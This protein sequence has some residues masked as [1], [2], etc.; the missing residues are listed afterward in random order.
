M[1]FRSRPISLGA[2]VL[3]GMLIG[4]AAQAQNSPPRYTVTDLG[5]LGGTYSYAYGLNDAD[6]VAGGAATTTQTNGVAETAFLWYGGHMID[7]GTLGGAACPDRRKVLTASDDQNRAATS[8]S[9]TTATAGSQRA[10]GWAG[11]GRAGVRSLVYSTGLRGM[12]S[13]NT[14]IIEDIVRRV[15]DTAQPEKV[16]LFGSRARGDFR[17]DSDFDLLVIKESDEPRYRRSV[18]LYVA[19]ADLPVEV[20]VVVYTPEEVA[21]WSGVPQAFVTTAM[22]EGTTIYERRG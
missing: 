21:E 17:R 13:V 3:L 19:L 7:L 16:I 8:G 18:P 10:H 12:S 11:A 2:L 5:T 14:G 4:P 9:R 1:K 22:R 20:E 15:V 6:V